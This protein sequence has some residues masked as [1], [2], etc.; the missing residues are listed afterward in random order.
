[1]LRYLDTLGAHRVSAIEG[2][3]EGDSDWFR[4]LPATGG[5]WSA[6][7][8]DYQRV[9]Y[10]A[11]RS[12]YAADVL[13][14]LS[15]S[16]LDWKPDDMTRIRGAAAFSD[17]VAIHSYVQHGQEPET[18]DDYASLDWYLTRMRDAFKPGAPVMA[19]EAGYNN[20]TR[21]KGSGI[22]E[23]AAAIYI[24]R[25]LLHNFDAGVQRT[26]LY[27]FMDGGVK[28]TDTEAHWGLVRHD[29]SA[30]PAYHAVRRLLAALKDD[31]TSARDASLR[32]SMPSA[33]PDIRCQV[34]RKRDATVVAAVW[35]TL[36]CWN[37]ET[38]RDIA[39]PPLPLDIAIEGPL[40]HAAWMRPH[41]DEAWT[42]I[43]TG[44]GK[45]SLPVG[46][47]VVLLRLSA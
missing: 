21:P 4:S 14:M 30:K 23:A 9:A 35:R 38:A 27:E 2:Q 36:R 37:V 12:R 15:P 5:D 7:V 20:V 24:P 25:L 45:I 40:A 3:N 17:I 22:S 32:V 26:F 44:S 18:P 46:D 28:P 39:T 13:P 10:L 47:H 31:Q 6:K 8:V 16:V 42:E 19:T 41:T 1:M 43:A 29:G 33:S 34:F 11:L